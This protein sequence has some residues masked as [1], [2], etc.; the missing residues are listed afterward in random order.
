MEKKERERKERKE[1]KK[2]GKKERKEKRKRGR[3]RGRRPM[4]YSSA[5]RR[6]DYQ[7]L[8]DQE[9]KL[10]YSTRVTSTYLNQGGFTEDPAREIRE[11]KVGLRKDS[12]PVSTL[13]EVGIFI[14]WLIAFPFGQ[15]FKGTS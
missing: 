15:V 12:Q 11:I 5:H 2:K 7:N 6:S 3:E 8:S 9:L 13:Q 10:V 1:R 14:L 4:G